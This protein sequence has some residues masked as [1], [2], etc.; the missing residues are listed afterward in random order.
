M[1]IFLFAD[2]QKQSE[3][4]QINCSILF[5]R[6]HQNR[7]HVHRNRLFDLVKIKGQE[8]KERQKAVLVQVKRASRCNDG[9]ERIKSGAQDGLRIGKLEVPRQQKHGNDTCRKH[10]RLADLQGQGRGKQT[11]KGKEQIVN[12]G[13]MYGK[14]REE[15][16]ALAGHH[17]KPRL[18]H[19]VEHIAPNAKIKIGRG[20]GLITQTTDQGN[21]AK[22]GKSCKG[23]KCNRHRCVHFY[24]VP[25]V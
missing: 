10:H 20:K 13:D 8:Q 6:K 19:V 15:C 7:T 18:L 17:R 5:D 3:E 9:E 21:H 25:N 23:G 24:I 11:V 2:Q 22:A 4:E 14:V 16:V 1:Q 12:G